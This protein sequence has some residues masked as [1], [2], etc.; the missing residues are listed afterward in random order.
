MSVVVGM[1]QV[2][3]SVYHAAGH[4]GLLQ[5]LVLETGGNSLH[6]RRERKDTHVFG[7][8]EVMNSAKFASYSD[9]TGPG[10]QLL[11]GAE[12]GPDWIDFSGSR[13]QASS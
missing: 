9:T 13:S 10:S 2:V 12:E 7:P 5:A 4:G 11:S 8:R 6:R 1:D 3:P